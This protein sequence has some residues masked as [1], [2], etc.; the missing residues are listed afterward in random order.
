VVLALAAASWLHKLV[1]FDVSPAAAGGF[2][3]ATALPAAVFVA[4]M[5]ATIGAGR[6]MLGPPLLLAAGFVAILVLGGL[7]AVMLAAPPRAEGTQ[8]MVAVLHL[9]LWGGAVFPLL[10]ALHH[11]WPE[12]TGRRPGEHSGRI[13][14]GLMLAGV[15]LTFLPLLALGLDG[16]PRRVHTYPEGLGWATPNLAA[17]GGAVV[18]ACGIAVLLGGLLVAA[19]RGTPV[20][21]AAAAASEARARSWLPLATALCV[22][23]LVLGLAAGSG[24][25]AAAGAASTALAAMVWNWPGLQRGVP[26]AR[27]RAALGLVL[28]AGATAVALSAIPSLTGVP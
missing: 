1:P 28:A 24:P 21:L 9:V 18:L 13:G 7:A 25:A 19:W 8:A 12:V 26:R 17:S 2:G 22:T 5:I 14:A 4:A 6:P 10:G 15:L 11:W 20:T 16:M 3:V 27:A 23:A